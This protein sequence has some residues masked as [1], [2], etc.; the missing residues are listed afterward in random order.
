MQKIEIKAEKRTQVGKP[1]NN[2]RNQ[3]FLPA[4]VYGRGFNSTPVQVNLKSFEKVYSEAGES[5]LVYISLDDATLPVIIHDTAKDP[6]SDKFIHVDFYKVNLDEKII[7]NVQLIFTGESPAIKEL[8]GI[9]V[10]NI[11]EVKIEALPQ[12]MPHE[13]EVDI[14]VLKTFSDQILIKS[15]V[16]PENVELKESSEDIIA[17]AQKPI[18]QEELEKQL[19]ITETTAE[20]VEVIKRPGAE[21]E[22]GV[23]PGQEEPKIEP[24]I[25]KP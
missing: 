4:V 2:L 8:A 10:K 7:A 9:L 6:V 20:E 23:E 25:K 18:S 17:L 16:L 21:I 1:L 12:N 22:D 19:A 5:S 3:G 24:E 13:I 14:S 11:S 15:L